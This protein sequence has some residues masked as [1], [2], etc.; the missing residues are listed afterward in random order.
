[1]VLS[2]QGK[3]DEAVEALNRSVELAPNFINAWWGR[4]GALNETGRYEAA[5]QSLDKYLEVN[6]ENPAVWNDKGKVLQAQ[7]RSSEAEAAF[8]RARELGYQG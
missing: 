2:S 1:M 4:G 6:P 7:G 8:A 5:I 3:Y